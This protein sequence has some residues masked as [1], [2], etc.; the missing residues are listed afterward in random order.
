MDELYVIVLYLVIFGNPLAR[1]TKHLI[2]SKDHLGPRLHCPPYGQNRSIQVPANHPLA[3]LLQ[4]MG[5]TCGNHVDEVDVGQ[6]QSKRNI[7]SFFFPGHDWHVALWLHVRQLASSV[8]DNTVSHETTSIS[9]FAPRA[10]SKFRGEF[11]EIANAMHIL[12][13]KP[14]SYTEVWFDFRSTAPKHGTIKKAIQ[15]PA[16]A[17]AFALACFLRAFS[18]DL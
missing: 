1:K 14:T 4:D 9:I 15:A 2:I 11:H 10:P 13:H 6:T 8:H 3:S 18:S 12:H 7:S 5:G 17:S 16:S